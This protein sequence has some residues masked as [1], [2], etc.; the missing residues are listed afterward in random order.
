[1]NVLDYSQKKNLYLTTLVSLGILFASCKT[2][3]QF[4]YISA[5]Y[6]D[7]KSGEYFEFFE[8]GIFNY[9]VIADATPTGINQKPPYSGRYKIRK[10][11]ALNITPIAVHLGLFSMAL[12]VDQKQLYVT[13]RLSGRHS[14]LNKISD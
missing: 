6:I 13:H 12:S 11:G 4:S 5:K 14:I 10:D 2:T 3:Q 1:M 9:D 7:E 8:Q